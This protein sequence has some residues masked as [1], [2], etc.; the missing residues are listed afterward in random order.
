MDTAPSE[1]AIQPV[2]RFAPSPN[3]Y[4]HLGHAYSA[5]LNEAL[6]AA[7]GG[8]WLLRIEDIDTTRCRPAFERAIYEDLAWL[9]LRW[10]EPVLR[11]S[12]EQA[13]Y[14]DA[15][16]RLD[17]R[18][19]LYPCA[20]SRQDIAAAVARREEGG[21]VWPRDPDGAPRHP[22]LV[23]RLSR[24][25]AEALR[26]RGEPVA[27]RL[28][29][30]R[31]LA[32]IAADDSPLV[33]TCFT[34]GGELSTVAAQ[35]ERWGDIVLARKDIGTSYHLSVVVD[36]ARQDVT[37]VVRGKD[38]EPATDLHCLLQRLLGLPTPRYLHHDLIQDQAGEKLAKSRGS[39]ALRDLR[40][41]GLTPE[42]LRARLGFAPRHS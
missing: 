19:L 30:E 4:L 23:E 35:P 24:T 26:S 15:L 3:G 20:A 16:A 36:D 18:G 40:A 14:R 9:G 12:T 13:A 25:E 39:T 21:A 2:F 27:W 34:A 29:M 7:A 1:R 42:D 8:L 38:L 33:W 5:L 11:Q 6:A 17:A 28:D 37:H 22:G 41:E 10:P 32:R 31:A